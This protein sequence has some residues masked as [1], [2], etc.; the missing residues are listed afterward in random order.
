ME[1]AAFDEAALGA[2][3]AASLSD[4]AKQNEMMCK[5]LGN[6]YNANGEGHEAIFSV[7]LL[8][9]RQARVQEAPPRVN[10]RWVC[11][12]GYVYVRMW[13]ARPFLCNP[14]SP[15]HEHHGPPSA[16]ITA[17]SYGHVTDATEGRGRSPS[18]T[19]KRWPRQMLHLAN[20][21]SATIRARIR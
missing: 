6:V 4:P 8:L 20:A 5:L 13:C 10:V 7:D 2:E 16:C 14:S 15:H 3:A 11:V 18:R 9:A 21:R 19:R 17:R 12:P 1:A